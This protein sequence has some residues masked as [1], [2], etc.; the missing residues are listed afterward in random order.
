MAQKI[1]IQFSADFDKASLDQISS[2]ISKAI[3]NSSATTAMQT[4]A[5]K[6]ADKLTDA[7]ENIEKIKSKGVVDEKDL[8]DLQKYTKEIEESLSELDEILNKTTAAP[9][10]KTKALSDALKKIKADQT[11][12]LE[13]IDEAFKGQMQ[14]DIGKRLGFD[15]AEAEIKTLNQAILTLRQNAQTNITGAAQ[16]KDPAVQKTMLDNAKKQNDEADKLAQ[17]LG[18]ITNAYQAY[19]PQVDAVN[20]KYQTLTTNANKA[21][22]AQQTMANN[23]H[24][25]LVQSLGGAIGQAATKMGAFGAATA[26]A[27]TQ[28][29][30]QQAQTV[31]F[32][33]VLDS[34]Q[35]KIK[36]VTS[37]IYLM[38][39]GFDILRKSISVVSGLDKEMTEIGIVSKQTNSEMWETFNQFNALAKDLSSTTKQYLEG[40][41]IF[42]QQGM[43]TAEV[44]KMVDA[45]TKAAALSSVSFAEASETLTAAIRA[46]NMEATMAASV[47]DKYAAVG[48]QSAAD[49][50]EL[51]VAM[52][53]VASSA[54][55]AGMSFD[56]TL[57]ILAKGIETTKEAPE[58]IGTALK[59]IIARFQEMKENPMAV[60]EDGVNANRVE[61][62]LKTVGVALRDTNGEFRD[63]DDV[64]NDLGDTWSSLS[65]NQKA[66][67]A[68]MAAGSRQQSRFMAIMNNY[69]RTLQ[70][71]RT[72]T[73]SAGEANRQY[74]IYEDSVEAAHNR[75]T[76]SLEAMYVSITSSDAIKF[77]YD[78]LAGLVDVITLLNPGILGLTVA[79][80]ALTVIILKY[81]LVKQASNLVTSKSIFLNNI[82][83]KD[84]FKRVAVTL[85]LAKAEILEAG[86][87]TTATVATGALAGAVALVVI[88]IVALIAIVV[89]IIKLWNDYEN[90]VHKA[91]S[92]A[93]KAAESAKEDSQI[94]KSQIDRYNE[95]NLVIN[96]TTEE[97][98]ELNEITNQLIKD[99]PELLA[100]IDAE[101]K[102]YLKSNAELE[103]YLKNKQK[104][105]KEKEAEAYRASLASMQAAKF[106]ATLET[107]AAGQNTIDRE[108]ILK[109]KMGKIQA[110]TAGMGDVVKTFGGDWGTNWINEAVQAEIAKGETDLNTLKQVAYEKRQDLAALSAIVGPLSLFSLG[111]TFYLNDEEWANYSKQ[112]DEILA[113][114]EE[115]TGEL[116]NLTN[117]KLS[118]IKA[119]VMAGINNIASLELDSLEL[120]NENITDEYRSLVA[121]FSSGAVDVAAALDPKVMMPGDYNLSAAEKVMRY[122]E[123]I[124]EQWMI[125]SE[126]LR[127][128]GPEFQKAL[129][130]MMSLDKSGAS[131]QDKLTAFTEKFGDLADPNN[132]GMITAENREMFTQFQK[133][134]FDP[135]EFQTKMDSVMGNI[136]NSVKNSS[137]TL[138]TDLTTVF[139]N[140]STPFEKMINDTVSSFG[141]EDQVL[142]D[143]YLTSIAQIFS[144]EDARK[145]FEKEL[146]E[147][148]LTDPTAVKAM[149]DRL[150]AQFKATGVGESIATELAESMIP[151]STQTAEA[152][153]KVA[154]DVYSALSDINSLSQKAMQNSLTLGEVLDSAEK[155]GV[156]ATK[157]VGAEGKDPQYIVDQAF[158]EEQRKAEEVKLT[159][160]LNNSLNQTI[161]EKQD[162]INLSIKDPT[163]KV[164]LEKI[165]ALDRQIIEYKKLT[166]T[167]LNVTRAEQARM[168]NQDLLTGISA[169][170][171]QMSSLKEL[172]ATFNELNEGPMS[173]LDTMD[174]IGNNP[175][176]IMALEETKDGL[177]L[178]KQGLIDIAD[179]KKAETITFLQGEKKKIDAS[180]AFV[181]AELA[182]T[183]TLSDDQA[184]AF[185]NQI[186][187]E[188]QLLKVQ[189]D[190]T[191]TYVKNKQVE[192]DAIYA[193]QLALEAANAAETGV[194]TSLGAKQT[195]DAK[196]FK[197]TV[198]S[199][200][201]M[202]DLMKKYNA[203][204]SKDLLTKL[205]KQSSKYASLIAEMETIKPE[206]MLAKAGGKKTEKKSGKK[207]EKKSG[208]KKDEFESFMGEFD[209]YYNYL[210]KIEK[211]QSDIS[212]IDAKIDLESTGGAEDIKL[213]QEKNKAL[214]Q[215][216]DVL[217][218]LISKRRQQLALDQAEGKKKYGDF[219]SFAGDELIVRWD[220][221]N[222]L[223]I[224]SEKEQEWYDN[225]LEYIDGYAESTDAI[226]EN[227]QAQL[228]NA[229]QIEEAANQMEEQVIDVRQRLYDALVEAD[230]KEIDA[231]KEKYDEMAKAEDE[232]LSAVKD[233][234][235]KERQMR[236]DSNKEEDLAAKKRKLAVLQRDTSGMYSQETQKLQGEINKDE[237]SLR[238][239]AVD[240]QYEAL[241]QQ[242]ELQ[243]EQRDLEVQSLD[244][245]M[246]ARQE[247]GYY[248]TMV[249]DA[250]RNGPQAMADILESTDAYKKMDPFAQGKEG[251]TIKND[252]AAI[253]E[254]FK[255]G[256]TKAG[257]DASVTDIINAGIEEVSNP[258]VPT[259]TVE[260]TVPT[261][262]TTTTTGGGATPYPGTALRYGSKG[263]MVKIVQKSLND[264]IRA[265]LKVDG[266]FGPATRTAVM[267]FQKKKGL[268]QDGVVGPKTWPKLV[269]KYKKGGLVDF[270]GPAW[271]DGTP[272]EP[273]SFLDP[274]GTRM[275]GN[276]LEALK[277]NPAENALSG[278]QINNP[279]TVGDITVNLNNPT[280]ASPLDIV[281]MVRKEI[282][283]TYQNRVTTSIQKSR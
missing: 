74:A 155:Y 112:F 210:Q 39:K 143:T 22:K 218:Q 238:D 251:E 55:T 59:T 109:E 103:K 196:A 62:A 4:A 204:D 241:Q 9:T 72:S 151:Q 131:I 208:S 139:M 265:G 81:I 226:E 215:E 76:N 160:A 19:K 173:F 49:F 145:A 236:D 70:L 172:G 189:A 278:T 277:R 200:T 257:Q 161:R 106:G 179:A 99:N 110:N 43:Q 165:A 42:Y 86:A 95:L 231:T 26:S 197:P 148:D 243:Q 34:V 274:E 20:T 174:A 282:L 254:I 228:E 66:Y 180:I 85:G 144:K 15:K 223:E 38:R 121:T 41:K 244:E 64:F 255:Q 27:S 273:E 171:S 52:E 201:L 32:G 65:R 239:Q 53:K 3:K 142:K 17:T 178:N 150:I 40:A 83:Q 280:N 107:G 88:G 209:R 118:E 1:T 100:G 275:V 188:E 222:A 84:L 89:V 47:T 36:Q 29:V 233:A 245:Q 152:F 230:Q 44:I 279:V 237:Q 283:N 224:S 187:G 168:D 256:Q 94:L 162:L 157:I 270:T 138:K 184:T 190:A 113:S 149:T 71:I 63:L 87:A 153:L 31:A 169:I 48:A 199:E 73:N 229:A 137:A 28:F 69:D 183:E 116:E 2:D 216:S 182:S 159:D 213:L 164:D 129:E 14:G 240:R 119:N 12:D 30:Q 16:S 249:D 37:V 124:Q 10:V 194:Y 264:A 176:L 225:L 276:L 271:V 281:K 147:T 127:K 258:T 123:Y 78:G 7:A 101:G 206:D 247:N 268:S 170:N 175:D 108:T 91:A 75:L 133:T 6:Y 272:G 97:K 219:V 67:I 5:K 177:R 90:A 248:W 214:K 125:E 115:K 98:A 192:I 93:R 21:A 269:T 252:V 250:I 114:T 128:Q 202:S 207:T 232:Y 130:D 146:E 77:L 246:A 181:E 141:K 57:G 212:L 33:G 154:K 51:S 136:S 18:K 135:K 198:S 102:A 111:G 195:I 126:K 235:D 13:S 80:G 96:K 61:K 203:T 54:Y 234:I 185:S 68:T 266:S 92:E 191:D 25:A 205:K 104:E 217:T 221:I 140:I 60:L 253:A 227:T 35:Q 79:I 260:P 117:T 23:Q 24:I 56:S 166:D 211:L 45:T 46:F 8:K 132:N 105:A 58:A 267:N 193:K 82:L 242:Y 156:G 11:K 158:L 167:I 261:T 263:E 120:N 262:P 134:I 50:H 259:T 186:Y 220:L 122:S 163:V